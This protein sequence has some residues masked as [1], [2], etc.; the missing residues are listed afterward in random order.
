MKG[1]SLVIADYLS[2]YP[3]TE[4]HDT[5][6]I[7]F[8]IT[9][10]QTKQTPQ[11][12]PTPTVTT[13]TVVRPTAVSNDTETQPRRRGR[14]PR[15]R[16]QS[17]E[18]AVADL[19]Q[20]TVPQPRPP[21]FTKP[22]FTIPKPTT[23]EP[24]QTERLVD[25]VTDR[26]VTPNTATNS[27]NNK[28][29]IETHNDIPRHMTRPTQKLDIDTSLIVAKHM[30]NQKQLS[31]MLRK[32]QSKVLKNYHLPYDKREVA[33]LQSQCPNFKDV[34]SYITEGLLP[35]NKAAA[36]RVMLIAEEYI[37]VD[38]ILFKLVLKDDEQ[39]LKLAVPQVLVPFVISLHHDNLLACHQG[40]V[41]L[42][43][44]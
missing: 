27:N 30:P 32:I 13:S 7:S 34:Y 38:R 21:D 39:C 9:R 28:T 37:V 40:I 18:T 15:Q 44:N 5:D 33:R 4:E 12:A 1:N 20:Q 17:Q 26:T 14:P 8:V 23:R 3:Q 22:I 31:E 29:V 36:K 2:R 25:T 24:K 41:S 10:S 42:S 6:D 35:P 16:T 19:R 43:N 11:P